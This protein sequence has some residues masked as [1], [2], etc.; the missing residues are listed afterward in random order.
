MSS[1]NSLLAAVEPVGLI[2][3]SA[4]MAFF[5]GC[6]GVAAHRDRVRERAV[7]NHRNMRAAISAASAIC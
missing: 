3:Y 4:T 1:V 7:A 6:V 2:A 5:L